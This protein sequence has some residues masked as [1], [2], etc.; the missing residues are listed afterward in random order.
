MLTITEPAGYGLMF[1]N[2]FVL[3]FSSSLPTRESTYFLFARLLTSLLP[4]SQQF[5]FREGFTE[6]F[7]ITI[8]SFSHIP[9]FSVEVPAKSVIF[10]NVAT[11]PLLKTLL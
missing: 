7:E 2:L 10:K 11:G 5:T 1:S 3:L 6:S 8:P 9:V 4:P